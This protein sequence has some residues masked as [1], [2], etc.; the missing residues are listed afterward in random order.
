MRASKSQKTETAAAAAASVK[1]G[2]G[3]PRKAESA[4]ASAA[5]RRPGRPRK[6]ESAAASSAKRGPGRPRKSESAASATIKRGPGRPRK[7]ESAA[8]ATK[9]RPGRPRKSEIAALLTPDGAH[10]ETNASTTHWPG[11]LGRQSLAFVQALLNATQASA[12]FTS[13]DVL[14]PKEVGDLVRV[15]EKEVLA[16]IERGELRA[17]RIGAKLRI[18]RQS[19]AAWLNS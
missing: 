13:D 17:T 15:R 12:A 11:D 3:R 2:P 14:T 1:R 7:T 5:K 6:A 19:V 9:R 8:T 4:A 10:A 16:A 18:T